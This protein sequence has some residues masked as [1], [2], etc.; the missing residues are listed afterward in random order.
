MVLSWLS[1]ALGIPVWSALKNRDELGA[2]GPVS[3][4]GWFGF[5][6]IIWCLWMICL[7]MIALLLATLVELIW[8]RSGFMPKVLFIGSPILIAGMFLHT[9]YAPHRFENRFTDDWQV[10][11]PKSAQVIHVVLQPG[12]WFANN[13][14]FHLRTTPPELK[15]IIKSKALKQVFANE[16]FLVT[17]AWQAISQDQLTTWDWYYLAP[18]TRDDGFG[19]KHRRGRSYLILCNPEM[20][21]A[22]F[23]N[24]Y[25]D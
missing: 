6:S 3:F 15:S 8:N 12:W 22:I 9:L 20:T 5:Y 21:E 4:D 16:D 23:M 10:P 13:D 7:L 24:Y 18:P 1:F 14:L 2:W 25:Y 17:K 11:F 19:H